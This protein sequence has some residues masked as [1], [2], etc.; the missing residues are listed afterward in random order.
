MWKIVHVS[1]LNG[2][3]YWHYLSSV[4][5]LCYFVMW[6]GEGG[7]FILNYGVV[8]IKWEIALD[9]LMCDLKGYVRLW[10]GDTIMR[11]HNGTMASTGCL[12]FPNQSFPL[13]RISNLRRLAGDFVFYCKDCKV[14]RQRGLPSNSTCPWCVLLMNWLFSRITRDYVLVTA[15]VH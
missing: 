15:I 2:R 5:Y 6:S 13:G 8:R 11:S 9:C 14:I 10:M 7:R 12:C 1:S 4:K 3:I